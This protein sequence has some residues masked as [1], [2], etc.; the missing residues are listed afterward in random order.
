MFEWVLSMEQER[1]AAD[2]GRYTR[3]GRRCVS[4]RLPPPNH[5][6]GLAFA[7]QALRSHAASPARRSVL[8]E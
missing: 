7:F 3:G 4:D 6:C 2:A 1:G 8:G 5:V